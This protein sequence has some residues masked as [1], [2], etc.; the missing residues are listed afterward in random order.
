MKKCIL[1]VIYIICL[2]CLMGCSSLFAKEGDDTGE[3]DN[4]GLKYCFDEEKYNTV[5]AS[6]DNDITYEAPEMQCESDKY[7]RVYR[8]ESEI[9]FIWLGKKADKINSSNVLNKNS[10]TLSKYICKYAN[11]ETVD[12]AFNLDMIAED[13][14]NNISRHQY[15]GTI[16]GINSSGIDVALKT[17]IYTFVVNK[18]PGCVLGLVLDRDQDGVKYNEVDANTQVMINSM[19]TQ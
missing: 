4:R 13:T 11:I 1:I 3:L 19:T 18:R 8:T 10:K 9:L 12:V 5:E 7:I 15:T 6:I 17:S 2:S 14:V 16:D